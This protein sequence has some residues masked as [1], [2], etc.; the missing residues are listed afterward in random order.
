MTKQ[1]FALFAAALRTY[2]PKENILPNQQAMEL[3]YRE[4]QDIAFPVIEAG[5]RQWVATNKWS[6]SIA[7]IR[8]MVTAVQHGNLPDWGEGWEKV[9]KAI[10]Y[11]GSY[12]ETEAL[13]GMDEITRT[14]VQRLGF[15][16]LCMS[17]NINADRANFRMIYEQLAERKKKESVLPFGLMQEVQRLRI[18]GMQSVAIVDMKDNKRT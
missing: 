10:R 9:L 1:E 4:L 13:A 11:F 6:P 3:W 12:G 18:G 17:E 14:C 7:D 5:L 16:N 2:Y 15:R 8:E